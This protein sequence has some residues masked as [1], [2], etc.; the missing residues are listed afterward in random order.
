MPR[1]LY[2]IAYDVRSPKRLAA[3]LRVVR[4]FSSGGQKSAY[5]C[6]LSD[7]EQV[8][9]GLLLARVIDRRVDSI[10]FLPL[11]TRQ[12]VTALGVAVEPADP[13]FFYFG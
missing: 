8:E 12:P 9:L 2:V 3:T 13:A 5:E 6:W 7:A 10:A 4:G 1:K 11:E